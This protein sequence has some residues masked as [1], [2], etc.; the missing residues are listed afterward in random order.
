MLRQEPG[1]LLRTAKL[2]SVDLVYDSNCETILSMCLS[3]SFGLRYRTDGF[4]TDVA[5]QPGRFGI[6]TAGQRFDIGVRG[7]G[8]VLQ[9]RLPQDVLARWLT[10]DHGVDGTRV[11]ITWD[12]LS[13]D[14]IIAILLCRAKSM[15]VE[16]EEEPIRAI[17]ARLLQHHAGRSRPVQARALGGL[18]RV[19]LRRVL[20]R[21]EEGL[22]TTVRL[23]DLAD[24][25]GL[26]PFHFARQ[27]AA[28]V[29]TSPYRYVLER[30]LSYAVDLLGRRD[31]PV[32]AIAARSGFAHTSHLSRHIHRA[33]GCAPATLRRSILV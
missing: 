32:A 19:R 27:F 26:S 13:H 1:S 18:T 17:A 21:I 28:T 22:A 20:D 9:L 4:T 11:E 3:C 5:P 10:E 15:G 30:R 7:T 2:T 16:G 33:F 23:D 6:M 25:A 8:T 14:P 29:G 12:Y 24:E 31:V